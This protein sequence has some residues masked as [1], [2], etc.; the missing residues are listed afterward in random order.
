MSWLS[1]VLD[2]VVPFYVGHRTTIVGAALILLNTYKA[3]VPVVGLPEVPPVADKWISD[4]LAGAG[5]MTL[6][7][8][9]GRS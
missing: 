2:T 8:K 4:T 7:A 1:K 5:S 6:L 3:L 9:I